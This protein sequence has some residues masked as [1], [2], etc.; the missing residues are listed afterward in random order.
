MINKKLEST[1]IAN[2]QKSLVLAFRRN[3]TKRINQRVDLLKKRIKQY[4]ELDLKITW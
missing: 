2:I 4:N 3:D 1:Q